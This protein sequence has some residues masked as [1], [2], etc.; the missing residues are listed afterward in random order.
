MLK[1]KTTIYII[2]GIVFLALNLPGI[3]RGGDTQPDAEPGESAANI[4]T[5]GQ[6]EH[7]HNYH[8]GNPETLQDHFDRHGGDFNAKNP[9]D[10]ARMANELYEARGQYQVKVDDRGLFRIYDPDTNSFGAYNK[11]G[12][13]RSFFKP[14][15][16]QAYFDR[17]PG[18]LKE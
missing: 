2:I 10:Y 4:Q 17:Q 12:S 9:Q 14:D 15:A 16:G 6:A 1:R 8:W 7:E 5:G 18:E 3:L 11:N 13:T